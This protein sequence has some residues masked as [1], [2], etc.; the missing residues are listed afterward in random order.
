[1]SRRDASSF[2]AAA[3]DR[4]PDERVSS[5]LFGFLPLDEGV[6]GPPA[7]ATQA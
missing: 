6:S 1:L 3:Y 2:S 7:S 4:G 5:L